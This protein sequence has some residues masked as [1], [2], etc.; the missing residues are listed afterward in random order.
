MNTLD[1]LRKEAKHWLKSVR[2]GNPGHVKRLRLAY[3]NAPAEPTL[4]DV[5]HALAREQGYE[6]WKALLDAL[7]QPA[8]S[9]TLAHDTNPA[10]HFLGFACWDQFVHG[11]GDYC[12][13]EA[14]AMRVLGAHPEIRSASIYT[15]AVCGDV[16]AV[17]RFLDEHPE[18][19][20]QKGGV[21][22]WEPLLYRIRRPSRSSPDDRSPEPRQP[23]RVVTVPAG[24]DRS[25][26]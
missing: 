25:V 5:Q 12:S 21:R 17:T 16:E 13:I 23:G 1:T 4:R 14:A 15:A 22:R 18:L 24:Q 10:S 6:S 20:N 9:S 19:V 3:P 8:I 2:T 26:A 7:K 11:R